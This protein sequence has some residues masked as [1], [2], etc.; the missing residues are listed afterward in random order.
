MNFATNLH[1]EE[2]YFWHETF[3]ETNDLGGFSEVIIRRL[4]SFRMNDHIQIY[5]CNNRSNWS[6]A[7]IHCNGNSIISRWLIIM[8]DA[9]SEILLKCDCR[10]PCSECKIIPFTVSFFPN[11][12]RVVL[13]EYINFGHVR[14]RGPSVVRDNRNKRCLYYILNTYNYIW[15]TYFIFYVSIKSYV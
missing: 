3:K 14:N 11:F 12:S 7:N 6:T 4:T 1:V 10:L 8:L 9:H 13:I 5:K 15:Y 2:I